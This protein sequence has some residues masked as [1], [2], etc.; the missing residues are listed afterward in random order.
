MKKIKSMM[1]YS[2]M[3]VFAFTSCDKDDD[4]D[5]N[6]LSCSNQEV[7]ASDTTASGTQIIYKNCNITSNETWSKEN[8]YVLN[9]RITVTNNATL[10]IQAGTV[11]KGAPGAGASATALV[12]ARDGKIMAN[13][14]AQDPI[15]FTSTA[16]R[17]EPGETNSPNLKPDNNGLWGGVIILG[18]A[19]ISASAEEVQI[20]GIPT[21]D[22]KGLYGGTNDAHSSGSFTYV[23]IRHGG[24]NIGAGNEIN[25]LT[26]GGVGAGTVIN[27]IEVVA[28]Q[29]DGIEWFGGSVSVSN[30]LIWNCGDDGLDTD[31]DW[32]GNCDNF[33]IVT[34]QGG[35]AF[36][37]D[38]PE[39]PAATGTHTFT[40]GTV[41]AGADIDHLVDW[42][43]ETNAALDG[44]YF[45]GLA[46]GYGATTDF[47]PFESFGGDNSGTTQNLQV[48]LAGGVLADLFAGTVPGAV[49]VVAA[50]TATVGADA[51]GFGW[52]W[53]NESGALAQIGL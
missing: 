28:N 3:A 53:A 27:N 38:G 52:T 4:D 25:G 33:L 2:A 29:D 19:H 16:D 49:S 20:E 8:I 7:M 18:E 42:D 35:S 32:T 26:L 37:L 15:I 23:S 17:I 47:D 50:G 31:Q 6:T 45:Y 46:A 43:D 36:E 40:N 9:S 44:V 10:T 12:I 24:T 39:G 5:D 13:G 1:L 34:P 14:T 51:S 48:T 30:V 41:Y 11:I 22:Q 21:S